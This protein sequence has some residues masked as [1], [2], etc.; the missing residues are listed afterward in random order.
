MMYKEDGGRA[1]HIFAFIASTHW[2]NT[3][4]FTEYEVRFGAARLFWN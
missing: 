3:S 4:R 1:A 2:K